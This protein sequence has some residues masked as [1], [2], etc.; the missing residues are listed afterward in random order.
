M[1]TVD[2][3]STDISQCTCPVGA[4]QNAAS[5]DPC[6]AGTY[7]DFNG[8]GPCTSCPGGHTTFSFPLFFFFFFWLSVVL[9]V[10]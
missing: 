4:Y 1:I 9:F 6:I 2:R 3:G 8:T 5:C 10:D 7:K